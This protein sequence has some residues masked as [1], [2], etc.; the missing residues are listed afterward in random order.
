MGIH[1]G[2]N[3]KINLKIAMEEREAHE[4]LTGS[5]ST[6]VDIKVCGC[7]GVWVLAREW[8]R[9]CVCIANTHATLLTTTQVFEYMYQAARACILLD[10]KRF[11]QRA[12]NNKKDKSDF[13]VEVLPLKCENI[14]NCPSGEDGGLQ[15]GIRERAREMVRETGVGAGGEREND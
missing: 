11:L 15:Q 6:V 8:L 14:L 5:P 12:Y 13:P 9:N 1:L 3:T 7:L 2:A 4:A 10:L